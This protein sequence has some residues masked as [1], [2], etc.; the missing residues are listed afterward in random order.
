M[1]SQSNTI[2]HPIRLFRP[3]HLVFQQNCLPNMLIQDNTSIR[4]LRVL[5]VGYYVDIPT[6]GGFKPKQTLIQ[7]GENPHVDRFL[8]LV[9]HFTYSL[10]ILYDMNV[11][12]PIQI[13]VLKLNSAAMIRL[14]RFWASEYPSLTIFFSLCSNEF[15]KATL[16]VLTDKAAKILSICSRCTT[17]EAK[18]LLSFTF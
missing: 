1:L 10:P 14:I 8:G 17:R 7:T 2:F 3:T 9:S 13:Y 6:L 5:V 11:H 16:C 4:N 15:S 12:K 18:Y